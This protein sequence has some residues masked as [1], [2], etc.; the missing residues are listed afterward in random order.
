MK[1]NAARAPNHSSAFA[2]LPSAVLPSKQKA[3]AG[4][5]IRL[6]VYVSLSTA[7]SAYPYGKGS[8]SGQRRN[9]L[10]GSPIARASL[11]IVPCMLHPVPGVAASKNSGLAPSKSS[12]GTGWAGGIALAGVVGT[13]SQWMEKSVL[14]SLLGHKGLGQPNLLYK[15]VV[16]L[17]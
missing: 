2:V 8:A 16:A 7:T 13:A 3:A 5:S 4:E 14:K 1:V 10:H 17:F 9:I 11:T 15:A 12:L 6:S